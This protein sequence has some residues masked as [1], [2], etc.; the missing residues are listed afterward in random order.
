[1]PSPPEKRIKRRVC[2]TPCL[3]QSDP[4]SLGQGEGHNVVI[5]MKMLDQ[6]GM[7]TKY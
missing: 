5:T 2:E 4:R 7:Y 3:R 6:R 1:M